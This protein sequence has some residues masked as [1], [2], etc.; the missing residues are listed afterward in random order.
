MAKYVSPGL[1]SSA[2]VG[3]AD[4]L[5]LTSKVKLIAGG[6]IAAAS[7]LSIFIAPALMIITPYTFIGGAG[8]VISGL[9]DRFKAQQLL[10]GS[11]LIINRSNLMKE[12]GAL[13][14]FGLFL[15]PSFIG[16]F[17]NPN[18]EN[19]ATTAGYVLFVVLIIGGMFWA[20]REE[21][22]DLARRPTTAEDIAND[23]AHRK[24]VFR[25][26]LLAGLVPI[27]AAIILFLAL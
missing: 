2:S 24:K 20:A 15:W 12:A 7:I 19:V 1:I 14:M 5:F 16:A 6:L 23:A 9:N 22:Q 25:S 4:Y 21:K 8:L 27:L 26:Y 3:R 10:S 18:K 11:Q 17:T 13:A